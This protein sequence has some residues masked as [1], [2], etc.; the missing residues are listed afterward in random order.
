MRPTV[1][2]VLKS[3]K[4]KMDTFRL[5]VWWVY[6][7][8]SVGKEISSMDGKILCGENI[9]VWWGWFFEGF[10]GDLPYLNMSEHQKYQWCQ[11]Y[12][13]FPKLS[14][15]EFRTWS[16][17]NLTLFWTAKRQLNHQRQWRIENMQLN[18]P[19][20]L[21]MFLFYLS[22]YKMYKEQCNKCGGLAYNI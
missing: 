18:V 12:R 19:N 3:L 15:G 10:G 21:S 6:S 11:Y 16:K 14:Y 20:K 13:I 1:V 9:Y 4:L 8:N 7:T 17:S 5:I 2:S 22:L